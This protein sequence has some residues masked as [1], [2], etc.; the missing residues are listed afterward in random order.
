MVSYDEIAKNN[1]NLLPSHYV[2]DPTAEQRNI[3]EKIKETNDLT[4]QWSEP[5]KLDTTLT[6]HMR[7]R[8]LEEKL[9]AIHQ[10]YEWLYIYKEKGV[11][12]LENKR[13]CKKNQYSFEKNAKLFVNIK[14]L[15]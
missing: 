5:K 1:F 10:I 7:R 13:I 2:S 3:S 15:R 8:T 6:V 4:A 14:N 9:E 11:S 12:G